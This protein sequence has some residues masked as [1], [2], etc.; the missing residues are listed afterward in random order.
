MPFH[1]RDGIHFERQE[2]GDVRVFN[3]LQL[4]HD[5][6]TQVTITVIPALEW[7]SIV[8]AMAH[9]LA[10]EMGLAD[11]VAIRLHTGDPAC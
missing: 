1:W 8:G 10:R 11:R 6:K 9:P 7:V 3:E 5:R 4:A 2:N